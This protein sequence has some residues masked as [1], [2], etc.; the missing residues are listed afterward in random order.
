MRDLPGHDSSSD[1]AG[2]FRSKKRPSRSTSM[3][4]ISDGSRSDKRESKVSKTQ[5]RESRQRHN[6]RRRTGFKS[7]LEEAVKATDGISET[8]NLDALG[9]V[10]L[11]VETSEESS[12]KAAKSIL[13]VDSLWLG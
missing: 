10:D 5:K 6:E 9:F 3:S 7:L 12:L 8:N 11:C 2:G 4:S 13:I 1:D